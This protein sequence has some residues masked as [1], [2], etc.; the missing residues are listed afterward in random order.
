MEQALYGS[1]AELYDTIY[2]WKDYPSEA[3]KLRAVLADEGIAP[4]SSLLEA[5]CG[6]GT[7][8]ALLRSSY[9]VAGFD[10]SG[11]MLDI[12]RAKVPGVHLF[13][14]DMRDFDVAEPVDAIVCLFSSFGYLLSDEDMVRAAR[15]FARALRPGGVLVVE[16]WLAPADCVSGHVSMHTVDEP[17]LKLCRQGFIEVSGELSTINHAW[18]IARRNVGVSHVLEKHVM[19]LIDHDALVGLVASAGFDAR[20]TAQGL[21]AK[22]GLLIARRSS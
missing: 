13:E 11:A 7:Y 10:R 6:T 2:N 18:L 17:D 14:A 4:G 3:E 16:P 15:S 22:R 8:L 5:A 19:R 1:L 20:F 21:M 12:A 9:R